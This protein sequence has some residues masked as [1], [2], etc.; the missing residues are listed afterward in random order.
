MAFLSTYQFTFI[1]RLVILARI[2]GMTT[3]ALWSKTQVLGLKKMNGN[4][5]GDRPASLT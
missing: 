5:G 3:S 1:V 2:L 4:G